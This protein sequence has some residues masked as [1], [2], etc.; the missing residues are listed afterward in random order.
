MRETGRVDN[1]L[2]DRLAADPRLPL[3]RAQ[4]QRLIE[5]RGS[6]TGLA[7][8]QVAA[9]LSRIEAVMA[10]HPDAAGYVPGAIL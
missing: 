5:D 10:Q 4:L 2:L 9:V 6:F 1:D 8:A 3:D 7:G